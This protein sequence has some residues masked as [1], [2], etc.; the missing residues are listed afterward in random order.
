MTSVVLVVATLV[1]RVWLIPTSGRRHQ[2]TTV[3]EG[4]FGDAGVVES[5]PE[6]EAP[7]T[8]ARYKQ[9]FRR[10]ALVGMAVALTEAPP[11]DWATL[12]GPTASIWPVDGPRSATWR[13]LPAWWSAA[14]AATW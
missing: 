3:I 13:S 14:S 4:P 1:T 9:V 7:A 12:C 8:F 5:S 11:N 6:P 2:T 10:L